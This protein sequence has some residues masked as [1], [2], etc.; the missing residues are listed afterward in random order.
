MNKILGLNNLQYYDVDVISTSDEWSDEDD[1]HS[2]NI[3]GNGYCVYSFSF[4]KTK[5]SQ[6]EEYLD[7]SWASDNDKQL[8]LNS[9]VSELSLYDNEEKITF[10]PRNF[11]D[12]YAIVPQN[13]I[14]DLMRIVNNK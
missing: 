3:Y 13:I 1:W 10:H 9:T 12:V 4:D 14:D 6:F 11:D 8:V 7:L 5:M 2:Y